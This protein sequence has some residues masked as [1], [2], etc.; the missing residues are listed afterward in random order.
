M[1][2]AI[3]YKTRYGATKQYAE[4]PGADLNLPI[5]ESNDL[6]EAELKQYDFVLMGTPVYVGKFQIA[7]WL[8]H[9]LKNLIGKKIF[10]FIV[11]G[12]SVEETETRSKIILDNIPQEI[13]PYCE[14]YFLKGRVIH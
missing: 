5:I 12:T 2:G 7:K 3:I 4:W 10:M 6:I 8:K 9:S 13:K 1:K 11:A 14:I